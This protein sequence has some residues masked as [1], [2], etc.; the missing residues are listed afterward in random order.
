MVMAR[1]AKPAKTKDTK[2]R[3]RPTLTLNPARLTEDEADYLVCLQRK[4]E[5]RVPLE[6]VM[7]KAGLRVGG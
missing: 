6:E 7:R 2:A 3:V 5:K 4:H 1:A